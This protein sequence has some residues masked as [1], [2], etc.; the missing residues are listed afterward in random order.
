MSG[1]CYAFLNYENQYEEKVKT[2]GEVV[3]PDYRFLFIISITY[4]IW[5]LSFKN[6][7]TCLTLPAANKIL[8][9][10]Q[11]TSN[12][13]APTTYQV[14]CEAKQ[15]NAKRHCTSYTLLIL[16]ISSE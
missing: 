14:P 4:L 9:D 2:N 13:S 5:I 15:S 11:S 16:H 12:Y 7:F 3:K 1:W 8:K 6:L 10:I